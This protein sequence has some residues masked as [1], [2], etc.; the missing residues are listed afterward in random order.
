MNNKYTSP[1]LTETVDTKYSSFNV[2][3]FN[4]R[5]LVCPQIHAWRRFIL[6]EQC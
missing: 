5:G 2:R 3:S 4:V 1:W 6:S